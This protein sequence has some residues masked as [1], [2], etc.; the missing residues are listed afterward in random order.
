M[1]QFFRCNDCIYTAVQL[2]LYGSDPFV[3]NE[4]RNLDHD[5][6]RTFTGARLAAPDLPMTFNQQLW[7]NLYTYPRLP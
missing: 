3:T 6:L 2:K 7:A 4:V 1:V 5:T